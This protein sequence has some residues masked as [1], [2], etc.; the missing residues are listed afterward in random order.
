MENRTYVKTDRNGTKYYINHTCP[1]CGGEGR[2][3]YYSHIDSGICFQCG[4]TGRYDRQEIERTPEYEKVL[5]ERRLA[6]ARREAV[7]KNVP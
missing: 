5:Q 6:K 7:A 1:R 3:S 2:I 4:G